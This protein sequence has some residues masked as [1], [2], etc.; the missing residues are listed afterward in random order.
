MVMNGSGRFIAAAAFWIWRRSSVTNAAARRM[1][2]RRQLGAGT[3]MPERWTQA[4]AVLL[5]LAAGCPSDPTPK[6]P[7]HDA[8][9]STSVDGWQSMLLGQ[10]VLDASLDAGGGIWAVTAEHVHY[11]P[12]GASSPFMY[13]Q[14]DGLARGWSTWSDTYFNGTPT[15][16]AVSP[17]TFSAVA[18]AT[19]GQ[20]VVGNTGAIADRLVVDPSTGRIQ[21]IEN[22][23]ITTTQVGSESLADHRERVVATHS[24]LVELQGTFSGTAY[25][26]GWHGFSALHGL[27]ADCGCKDFEEHQ[28][29]IPGDAMGHCDSSGPENGCWDGDVWGL[30]R[31]AEGDIW[32][33]D[34]HF[35]QLLRQRSIGARAGLFDPAAV[36][37]AAI[38][39]WPGV[40]DEV[41]GLAV[42]AAGG[43]WVA[44]D[45]NGLAYL[46]PQTHSPTFFTTTLPSLHLHGVVVDS[47][48]DVWIGTDGAGLVRHSPTANSWDRY[49]SATSALPSNG[50]NAL[51]FDASAKQLLVATTAGL[52]LFQIEP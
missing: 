24:I 32:A 30:A 36:W 51:H 10:G 46:A 1:A 49:T 5:L 31:T 48:G 7:G 12:P 26:G 20:A 19:S 23:V 43:L 18:G 21:R 27:T 6:M 34:R 17:V 50:I 22:L 35:V 15:H 39:V 13:D 33:G 9:A 38:D 2:P 44:S 40:R 16:P 25:L 41:H 28:H 4:A 47:R 11:F 52:A 37:L 14:K 45:G 8:G 3:A 29:F 42:D